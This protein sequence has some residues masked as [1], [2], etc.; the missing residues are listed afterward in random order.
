MRLVQLDPSSTTTAPPALLPPRPR[1]PP[2]QKTLSFQ[3]WCEKY[4]QEIQHITD[5]YTKSILNEFSHDTYTCSLNVQKFEQDMKQLLYR[6][7]DNR[8]KAPSGFY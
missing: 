7:S 8:F 1:L 3:D 4:K 2:A 5:L 6:K